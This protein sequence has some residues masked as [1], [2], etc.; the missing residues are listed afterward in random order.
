MKFWGEGNKLGI[1]H[2]I[3]LGGVLFAVMSIFIVPELE[4]SLKIVSENPPSTLQIW[5]L[6]SMV[7]I[8]GFGLGFLLHGKKKKKTREDKGGLE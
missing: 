6:V 2:L 7:V 5:V 3:I 4:K 1:V 8:I